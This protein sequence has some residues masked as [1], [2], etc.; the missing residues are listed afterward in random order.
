MLT[1]WPTPFSEGLD[2]GHHAATQAASN[3]LNAGFRECGTA[4]K[5][6]HT[7]IGN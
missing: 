2:E 7:S 3:S 6:G 5:E 1:Q 4:L